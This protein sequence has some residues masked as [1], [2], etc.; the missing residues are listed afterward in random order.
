MA[1]R[2]RDGR[3]WRGVAS[4]SPQAAR[5]WSGSGASR[6]GR[7]YG[8]ARAED[9]DESRSLSL[10]CPD[11]RFPSVGRVHAAGDPAGAG[12]RRS[13]RPGAGGAPDTRP[14]LDHGAWAV[15]H[16]ARRIAQR[17]RRR[18]ALMRSC[19][20]RARACTRFR[21]GR[22]MPASSSPAISAS[23]PAARRSCGWR[24]GSATP[25][26]ASKAL[27][28]GRDARARGAARRRASPATARS[29]MR[30]PSPAPSR[31]RSASKRRRARVWLRALMAEL[32]RLAN[33]LGDIGAICN[34]AVVRA[35]ARPLR[36]AARA[37]AA[38]RARR[39]SAIG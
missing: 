39:A 29:P 24:S 16:A 34:D 5:R 37:R 10:R 15:R 9:A 35:D 13:L 14:W 38:R 28:R 17:R 19:R 23:P 27:M 33:H 12:G 30:S 26:R 36:R 7:A 6:H 32:E 2:H 1:A 4:G 22:S 11:G 20:S 25:I 8:A 21:S 31:R 18:A 3:M